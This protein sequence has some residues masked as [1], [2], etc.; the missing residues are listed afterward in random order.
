MKLQAAHEFAA[1][2]ERVAAAMT[3]PAFAIGLV[4]L[5][6]VGR[7]EVVE[8]VPGAASA[9][10]TIRMVY[11]GALDP[12][13]ARVLGSS[14]PSWLQ[15]YQVG[16]AGGTLTISPEHHGSLLRCRADIAFTDT[17]E[18]CRRTM[19]GE[20]TVRVPLVGGRAERALAPAINARIDVEAELLRW[21]LSDG[22]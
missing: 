15:T 11:D 19:T 9:V 4:G 18:G 2:P 3:D 8:S 14:T 16:V 5:P 1:P 17:A 21:W 22:A 13:A 20:L 12:V 10:L 7:V 6:D